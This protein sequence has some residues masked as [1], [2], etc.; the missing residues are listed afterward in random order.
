MALRPSEWSQ[1]ASAVAGV[2]TATRAGEPGRRHYVTGFTLSAS[3]G[4]VA[5]AVAFQV[6]DTAVNIRDQVEVPAAVLAPL[7][8]DYDSPIEGPLGASVDATVPSLGAGIK[9]TV[10]IRGYTL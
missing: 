1:V 5:A 2:A 9:G 7:D 10:V 3:G 6:R 8:V 4:P